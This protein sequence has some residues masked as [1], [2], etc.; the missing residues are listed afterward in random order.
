MSDQPVLSCCPGKVFNSS[1]TGEFWINTGF[2]D[3]IRVRTGLSW[4]GSGWD[5]GTSGPLIVELGCGGGTF[6][7]DNGAGCVVGGGGGI[8][9]GAFLCGMGCGPYPV[10]ACCNAQVQANCAL[11]VTDSPFVP[12]GRP[13][14]LYPPECQPSCDCDNGGTSGCKVPTAISGTR[15][16]SADR[17]GGSGPSSGGCTG[18]ASGGAACDAG[19]PCEFSAGPIRYADGSI[20]IRATDLSS[21]GFSLP[22]GHTRSFQ[23]RLSVNETIGNGFNWQVQEWP[24]LAIDQDGSVAVLGRQNTVVLFDRI[25]SNYVARFSLKPTLTLNVTTKRY[26]YREQNGT[27]TEFDQ[28]TG[29]FRKRTDAAGNVIEVTALAGN[30]F[31]IAQVQRSYSA[32]GSSAIERF[33]YAYDASMGDSLLSS[34]TL[35]RSINGGAFEN[36]SKANY[37]YYTENATYG[38]YADLQTVKT[39]V[40]TGSSWVDTGTTYYRYYR[41]LDLSSSSSSSSGSSS[42]GGSS[43]GPLSVHL[44]KY[45]VLPDSFERLSADPS[46]TDPLSASDAIVAQYADNYFEYDQSRRVTREL[47]KGGSQSFQFAY[48]E[49][50]NSNGYNSWKYKTTETLPDSSLRIRYCNYAGQTMLS[51]DKS[52]ADQ[53]CEFWLYNEQARIILHAEP[54]AIS[55]YDDQYADLLHKVGGDY[56]F[57]KDNDGLIETFTYHFESGWRASQSLQR[58]EFGSS[59]KLREF[60]YVSCCGASSSSS[61]SSSASSASSGSSSSGTAGTVCRWFLSKSTVY[62]S[63]T[64]QTVKQVTSYAYTFYSGTCAVEEKTTTY[65]VVSADQNGSGVAATVREYFDINGNLIWQMDERGFITRTKYDVAT[66]AITQ[67]IQDVD[68]SVETDAPSGWTTP[69]GGGLNLT[70]DFEHNDEGQMTQSLGPSHTIDLNG[71]ATTIRRAVWIVHE[72]SESGRVTRMA[73][74]YATGS[75]GSYTY[76]LVNPVSITKT[77]VSGRTT[78]QIQATRASTSGKLLPTDTFAQTSYTR[79]TTTTYTDCC[80]VASQRTYHTIPAS[81]PGTEGTNYDETEYGYDVMKR[82]NRTVSPGGTITFNVFNSRGLVTETWIGTNDNGATP[83]DP[84]GAGAS[85]NNMVRVTSRVY[86]GGTAGG[87]GNVTSQ[88]QY[89]DVSTTRVTTFGYDFRSRQTTTDGE[90][91]YYEK[92][93]YDNLN[94]VIKVERFNTTSGGNLIGKSESKYD[95]RGRVYRTIRYAVDP[96]TGTVGNSLTDNSWFDSSGHTIKQLPAGSSRFTKISYDSLG[97]ASTR[98][99]GYDLD[100]TSYSEASSVTDDTIMEQAET[101]FDNA[102]N[103]IQQ[104]VRQ[105]YHN[106][107]ASQ[108]GA[109][110]NPTA[111]PKARVTYVATYPDALGRTVASASYGTNGGTT[112]SRSA[113]IPTRSDTVLVTTTVYS[114]AGNQQSTKDPLAIETR[115]EHDAMGRETKRI[116]NYVA[117]PSSS[118]SSSG[119]CAPSADLN[120]TVETTWN[121]DGNVKTINAKNATTGDQATE[122]V[123]GTTLSDSLIASSLLKRAEIYP[124]SVDG[125]DKILFEYNRQA[126]TIKITDQAGTVHEF[127]FD[128]LG[129]QTHDRVTTLGSGVDGGVR[130]IS[131]TYEV[132]GMRE[133]VTSY[134][135][136]TVGSGSIVNDTK[137]T[138]NS[139]GQL[140]TDYQSHSGAVNTGSSPKV[141]YAYASGSANTIRPTTITY[142]NGRVVTYGYDSSNSMADALSRVAAVID[143]DGGA[144]HLA[145][146]SY[147][148]RGTPSPGLGEGR[149]EGIVETDYTQPDV[150]YTL[151]GTAGGDDPNTGDIYRGL[152]RFGRIKDSYWYNYGTSADADRIKY[153]YDRAGSR[154]WRENTVARSQGKY[155]DEKYVYDQIHRLKD[156][157]RGELGSGGSTLSNKQFAQC[158]GL[159]ET[160]NWSN[161]REDNTGAGSWTLNQSRTSN[162]VNEITD[163]TKTVGASWVTPVYSRAGNMTTMP[164]PASPASSYTATYDAW[165]RLVKIASGANTVSEYQYD[166]AKRRV[167]QKSYVSGTLN[168]TR[169]LYYT[170]PGKWQVVEER[171]GT[172]TSANRQFVWGLRYIDDLILRDRDTDGNGTLD[173]RLYSLQD[174]NWNVTG[175]VNSSG[176]MQQRF[177]YTAYG[178]PVF[179][180]SSFTSGSNTVGW[181]VLYAGYRF[182]TTTSLMHV[183]HRVL[184]AA[185]G[186]WVQRDPIGSSLPLDLYSYSASTPLANTDPTGMII[187]LII[188][189]AGATLTA[190]E[191]KALAALLGISIALLLAYMAAECIRVIPITIDIPLDEPDTPD[192]REF[193]CVYTCLDTESGR[194]FPISQSAQGSCPETPLIEDPAGPGVHCTRVEILPG[195]CIGD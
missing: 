156:M 178:L 59:I 106:A 80:H 104:T 170:E 17:T 48:S 192:Y 130:R 135:N 15:D 180:N 171:V 93:T 173:E 144:T 118:S 20:S 23:S 195:P 133:S 174:A 94:R 74:G 125:S 92:K 4:N 162:T 169:H 78:E 53:W 86:D 51:V 7:F 168:E 143:N 117:S 177:V 191:L 83:T 61:S 150:R 112:L 24:H 128:K 188:L 87:D 146:Y 72:E 16:F 160:G 186:C 82:R 154:I 58:G 37:T 91:D 27:I 132:R 40:W 105:R 6:S 38:A 76:T 145:D 55:G 176:V 29:V 110:Q 57:L 66:G 126:E 182:E 96:S 43:S 120:V 116:M 147:L 19:L 41:Q 70:T 12:N 1:I 50:S 95:D 11:Y 113:A 21:D 172:S 67:Q 99:S 5:N 54:S 148:G 89:V 181:E 111:T 127:D 98:Y 137:F 142:P 52:G 175:L 107:A 102:G 46:V 10:Q 69:S 101:A 124:D 84:S 131:S 161:F 179:L 34:V 122:Y 47:I 30:S 140:T 158:W 90:I 190:A 18:P 153:G 100:E 77:D 81:G 44:L 194:I 49:S 62:P 152:D 149:G 138:Y 155:F 157:S 25:N 164:Q 165:N 2:M 36:V 115:S 121:A 71:T 31:N 45:V 193:C 88:T 183:R 68:T 167:V 109:L 184:S 33:Q 64:D 35:S 28:L 97:R 63:D 136:A 60:E 56:E 163:I 119:G 14:L 114:S 73:A 108:L 65:P 166:G 75:A 8:L 123:Y 22:W 85:G 134:D 9:C 103:A 141:Q 13:P 139:F 32:G 79:W 151:V 129:R 185:L 3:C 26:S 189:A 187:P 39:Q 42:S 159:D